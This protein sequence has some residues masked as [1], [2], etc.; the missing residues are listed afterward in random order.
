METRID[1]TMTHFTDNTIGQDSTPSMRPILHFKKNPIRRR[2]KNANTSLSYTGDALERSAE[3]SS[4]DKSQESVDR[5]K[6][7][8][9]DFK[10]EANENISDNSH[11]HDSNVWI[12][13]KLNQHKRREYDSSGS[14]L[15]KSEEDNIPIV[16]EMLS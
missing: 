2:K 11:E 7:I 3:L 1:D 10:K 15:M 4:E 12:K 5:T 13:R 16:A 8:T 6:S 14:S 9:S